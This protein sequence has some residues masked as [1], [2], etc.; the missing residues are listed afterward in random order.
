MGW[1]CCPPLTTIP[2]PVLDAISDFR[3]SHVGTHPLLAKQEAQLSLGTMAPVGHQG[4]AGIPGPNPGFT[5]Q[6]EILSNHNS[7]VSYK[8]VFAVG[9]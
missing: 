9:P 8:T 6:F 3:S 2:H 4:K 1:A 7:N 5:R